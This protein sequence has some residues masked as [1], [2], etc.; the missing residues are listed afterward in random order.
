MT[1][2]YPPRNLIN[3]SRY[4][5]STET[6]VVRR[7]RV[8]RKDGKPFSVQALRFLREDGKSFAEDGE[9]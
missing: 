1:P 3:D 6:F 5:V 9:S 7:G 2:K 8:R 4:A